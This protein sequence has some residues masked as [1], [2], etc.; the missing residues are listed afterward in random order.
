MAIMLPTFELATPLPPYPPAW[1]GLRDA[2]DEPIWAAA[3]AANADYVVSEN[4]RDY[5]PPAPDGRHTHDRIEYL[6]ADGFL[7]LLRRGPST[8]G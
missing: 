2:S 4:R 1:E 3:K 6:P 7:A 8:T 5:P